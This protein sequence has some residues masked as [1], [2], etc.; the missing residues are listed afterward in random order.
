MGYIYRSYNR[1]SITRE[2][3]VP[4]WVLLENPEPAP[5]LPVIDMDYNVPEN[6]RKLDKYRGLLYYFNRKGELLGTYKCLNS[7]MDCNKAFGGWDDFNTLNNDPVTAL[8]TPKN[9]GM[10][11]E[12]FAF[13][14]DS[15][16]LQVKYGDPTYS[17]TVYLYR[18]F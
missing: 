5:D 11:L 15:V 7:T 1:N 6:T 16:S 8:E 18:F 17:R 13:V 12:K 14:D 10:I 2:E 9:L 3:F 4:F